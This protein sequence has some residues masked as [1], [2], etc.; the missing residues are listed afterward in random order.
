M[1]ALPRGVVVASVGFLVSFFFIHR[2]SFDNYLDIIW[3]YVSKMKN[4]MVRISTSKWSKIIFYLAFAQAASAFIIFINT[5]ALISKMIRM[6]NTSP[7]F[8]VWFGLSGGD[9]RGRAFIFVVE[10]DPL[11]SVYCLGIALICVISGVFGIIGILLRNKSALISHL[12]LSFFVLCQA[13]YIFVSHC[14][15]L[16]ELGPQGFSMFEEGIRVMVGINAFFT[17]FLGKSLLI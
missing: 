1:G 10:M 8:E 5:S 16:D 3:R 4:F 12:G 17:M 15:F 7:S 11:R 14:I 13:G 9:D 2:F 6:S